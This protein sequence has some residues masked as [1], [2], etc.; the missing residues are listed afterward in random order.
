MYERLTV[1]T[2]TG[3]PLLEAIQREIYRPGRNLPWKDIAPLL[4][5]NPQAP[6]QRV[7]LPDTYRQLIAWVNRLFLGGEE[8]KIRLLLGLMETIGPPPRKPWSKKA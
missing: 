3:V 6:S 2:A 7:D 1:P 4:G 8:E 5:I